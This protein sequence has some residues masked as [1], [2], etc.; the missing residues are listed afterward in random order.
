MRIALL[1]TSIITSF[2]RFDY[3]PT[4]LQAVKDL[5]LNHPT[6][7][8]SAIG[9]KATAEILSEL[10][11]TDIPMNRIDYKQEIDDIAIVFKLNRRVEEGRILSRED[12]EDIGYSFAILTKTEGYNE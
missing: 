7:I 3:M 11:A 1:N 9:H 10:L 12:I 8:L 5:L 6:D 2:G 4:T